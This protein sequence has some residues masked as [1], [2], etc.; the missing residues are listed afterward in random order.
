MNHKM[1]DALMHAVAAGVKEYVPRTIAPLAERVT[2]LEARLADIESAGV[3]YCGIYQRAQDY[4]RGSMVTEGG[5]LWAA[6]RDVKASEVPG[7]SE[8]W[9][10][11]VKCGRD[12]KDSR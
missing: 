4:F 8:G 10:L 7:R 2:T 9:Q 6:T 12:G 3:K 11:A 5:S 1:I